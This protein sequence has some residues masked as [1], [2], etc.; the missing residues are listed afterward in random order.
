MTVD[1]GQSSRIARTGVS[2]QKLAFFPQ[3]SLQRTGC[4]T[5]LT[6]IAAILGLIDKAVTGAT[7]EIGQRKR[8]GSQIVEIKL[9]N[10]LPAASTLEPNATI[11]EIKRRLPHELSRKPMRL[12]DQPKF[13]DA[14]QDGHSQ[15]A[16][17]T[18]CCEQCLPTKRALDGAYRDFKAFF[19]QA[20]LAKAADLLPG[21]IA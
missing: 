19:D 7:E 5:I 15:R 12:V 13:E 18:N 16:S 20:M 8:V 2:C 17:L 1:F 21:F 14:P 3:Q 11:A 9:S 10:G 4:F 6:I